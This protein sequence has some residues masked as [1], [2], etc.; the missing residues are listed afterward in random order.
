MCIWA[1]GDTRMPLR[2]RAE[3]R[4]GGCRTAAREGDLYLPQLFVYIYIM[5]YLLEHLPSDLAKIADSYVLP[6]AS[7]K[8][9][10][11]RF[12]L[13]DQIRLYGNCH[14]LPAG[15]K[16]A[17][18]LAI[19]AHPIPVRFRSCLWWGPKKYGAIG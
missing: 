2:P 7:R 1:E 4:L 9:R 11:I 14:S 3:E 18:R 5:E 10:I 12:Q 13:A 19:A 16:Q 8:Q 15:A 17:F 6:Y